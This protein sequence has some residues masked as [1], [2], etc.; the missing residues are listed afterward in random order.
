MGDNFSQ[1]HMTGLMAL[2]TIAV[3]SNTLTRNTAIAATSSDKFP[4]R[5]TCQ[6]VIPLAGGDSLIYQLVG[7]FPANSNSSPQNLP[8]STITVHRRSGSQKPQI[9]L[10]P[11]ST[12]AYSEIAPDADYSKL[13][14][15]GTFRG[16]PNNA[17]H[18]YA[19]R[20]SV[21]GLYLSLRPTT[22]KPQ[23][24]Q[25]VHYLSAVKFMRSGNGTGVCWKS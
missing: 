9:L 15:T 18:L 12:I 5:M 7:S 11:T 14:F 1:R 10:R 17:E 21:H 20:G 23:R 25:I 19:A 6:A 2:C 4:D 8:G 16:Q 24:M 13:P 22:G 3:T